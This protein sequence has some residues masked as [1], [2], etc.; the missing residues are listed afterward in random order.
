MNRRI[1]TTLIAGAA[2]LTVAASTLAGAGNA[3]AQ[4]KG[5]E[6]TAVDNKNCTATFTLTNYTNS[7]FYQPD[8]WFKQEANQ[9]WINATGNV[10]DLTAPWR[11]VNGIPWPMARWVQREDGTKLF[12][13]LAPGVPPAGGGVPYN[14]S[15]QPDGFVSTATVNLKTVTNPAPPAPSPEGTQ[16]IYYR[17][18]SGPQTADRRPT[19]Q[20][21]VVT[22]CQSGSGSLDWGSLDW[23]SLRF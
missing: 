21:L 3:A 8:W 22:G 9:D 1:T 12:S 13:Q 10:G 15:A 23:G 2:S 19:P 16:T 7:T 18:K 11:Y 6:I 20:E 4:G 14:S 5:V 17:I